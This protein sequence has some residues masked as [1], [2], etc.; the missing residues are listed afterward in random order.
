[1]RLSAML[2]A[3]VALLVGCGPLEQRYRGNPGGDA[4][5]LVA[6]PAYRLAVPAPDEALL[7]DNGAGLLATAVAS[8][9]EAAEVPAVPGPPTPLDWRLVIRAENDGAMVRPRYQL[10][11]ADGREMGVTNGPPVPLRAWGDEQ[12]ATLNAIAASAAPLVATLLARADATR[13]SADPDSLRAGTVPRL[14]LVP[15]RGAPGDGNLSLT[16]RLS[17][18]LPREGFQLQDIA[19]GAGFAVEG[20]VRVVRDR[21][22][23]REDQAD[24]QFIIT[25]RDGI[26]LGRVAFVNNVPTGSLN[27]FWGDVAYVIAETAAPGIKQVIATAGGFAAAGQPV[28]G[29][30]AAAPAAP[31]AEPTPAS[32]ALRPP[33]VSAR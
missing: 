20:V 18:F 26:E 27:G 9:L 29:A 33:P 11:D 24:I 2:L 16:A 30:P 22:A 5:R 4:R 19:D 1:M 14:R 13:R 10:T 8:A 25:R 17:E 28:Q 12:P 7:S 31:A 21:A 6:P 32:R 23:P 3:L 15:V